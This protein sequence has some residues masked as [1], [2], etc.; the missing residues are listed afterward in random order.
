MPEISVI[1]CTRNLRP[2]Y[3]RRV[4]EALEAQTYPSQKWELLIVDNHPSDR[5]SSPWEVAWHPSARIVREEVPGLT[6]ARLRGMKES[7]AAL[8]VF[9]DDDNLLTPNYLQTARGILRAHPYLGAFGAGVLEPEYEERPSRELLPYLRMMAIRRV[10]AS[11]WSNNPKDFESIPCGAGLCVTR[12]VADYY[13]R[14]VDQLNVSEILDRREEHLFSG[15]DD[16]VSWASAGLKQGFG[17]FPE[18]RL[19]H[20]ISAERLRH[21]YVLRLIHDHAY[22]HSVLR[23]LLAGIK[24]EQMT[25]LEYVRLFLHG[26]R[27]GLFSMRCQWAEVRGREQARRFVAERELQ[28]VSWQQS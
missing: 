25:P 16:L 22:S 2:N 1:V 24:D 4:L 19:T 12:K 3:S 5:L 27:N 21:R 13:S 26:V 18:L 20:L 15:G 8:L 11:L 7:R 28:P 6:P 17:V 9:V 23:H 10:D 14:L